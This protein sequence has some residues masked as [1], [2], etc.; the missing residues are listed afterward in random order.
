MK[1]TLAIDP[2]NVKSAYCVIDEET[3]KPISFGILPNDELLRV[4]KLSTTKTWDGAVIEMVASYGMPVGRE[5]FDTVLWIGRFYQALQQC[6]VETPRLLCR[7]EEK[8]HICHNT[9]ANDA[10]IRRALIDRFATHDLKNGRGTKA[11]P[12]WFYGFKADIWAAYAVGLTAIEN[13]SDDYKIA[14][15]EEHNDRRTENFEA[16]AF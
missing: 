8:R 11:N 9:R 16:L 5:V 12:D 15:M 14:G 13:H 3:L 10:T 2:G 7:I 1:L 6:C 4:L